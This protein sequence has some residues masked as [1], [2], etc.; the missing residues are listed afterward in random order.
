MGLLRG[1][2][3]P[4]TDKL[5]SQVPNT[6]KLAVLEAARKDMGAKKYQTWMTE[7]EREGII[8]KALAGMAAE[9]GLR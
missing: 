5:L 2:S 1:S 6:A 9:K 7:L 8:S 3:D 4:Y